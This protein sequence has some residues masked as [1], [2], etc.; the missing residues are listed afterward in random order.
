MASLRRAARQSIEASAFEFMA[1]SLLA[2]LDRDDLWRAPK[3]E[4]PVSVE[5]A[6]LEVQHRAR[7]QQAREKAFLRQRI[8][9]PEVEPISI[10][11]RRSGAAHQDVRAGN[12][13]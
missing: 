2:G 9:A 13:S 12:G 11:S 8:G 10:V 5:G 4:A 7:Y 6:R 1:P 3:R